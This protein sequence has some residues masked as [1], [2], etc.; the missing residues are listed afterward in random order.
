MLQHNDIGAHDSTRRVIPDVKRRG[1]KTN[2]YELTVHGSVSV[3]MMSNASDIVIT[4]VYNIRDTI[5]HTT[6]SGVFLM[7]I[8]GFCT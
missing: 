3:G 6:V 2:E 7:S 5:M 1:K 4:E 8:C